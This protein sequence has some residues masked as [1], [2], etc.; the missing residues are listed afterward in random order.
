MILR[1]QEFG[2]DLNIS[3]YED[4]EEAFAKEEVHLGDFKVAVEVYINKLVESFRT[5]FDT[6][7]LKMLTAKV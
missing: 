1:K 3:L 5:A 4:L 6:P 2:G 7:E